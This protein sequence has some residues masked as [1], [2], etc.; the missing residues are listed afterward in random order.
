M[1]PATALLLLAA[2]LPAAAE[3]TND[4][5]NAALELSKRGIHFPETP[6]GGDSPAQLITV[7][8]RSGSAVTITEVALQGADAADFTI[9]H[10]GCSGTLA[11][12]AGCDIR[13]QFTPVAE[14]ERR[15]RLVL[16]TDSAA[17]REL[18]VLLSNHE[19]PR[20]E[21]RRRLPPVL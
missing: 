21:A 1:K 2:V 10:D 7:G 16:D 3:V 17:A 13:V 19:D 20:N 18:V 9:S 8:N 11:A 6:S 4:P 14:G 15:A 5:L 12:G